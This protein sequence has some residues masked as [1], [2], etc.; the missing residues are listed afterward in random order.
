MSHQC[1]D[2]RDAKSQYNVLKYLE[3]ATLLEIQIF[4]GRTHQIRVHCAAIG[5]G[6]LGDAAYGTLSPLIARQALHAAELEFFY[7]GKPFKYQVAPPADFTALV[8]ALD[9]LPQE[10]E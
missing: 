6:V 5:H 8:T 10:A 2:G 4:T 1:V 7:A 3:G 9:T